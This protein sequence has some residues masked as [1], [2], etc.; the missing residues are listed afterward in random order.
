MIKGKQ[1]TILRIDESKFWA[2]VLKSGEG[3]CW[4]WIG[5]LRADGYGVIRSRSL[6]Y[7]AHR[8]AYMLAN[9]AVP[10]GRVVDHT[11]G[12]KACCN[13]EHLQAVT[14]S[15]NSRRYRVVTYRG[16]CSRGHSVEFGQKC[17]R[18]NTERVREWS[19]RNPQRAAEIQ[20][21]Y[22]WK[23]KERLEEAARTQIEETVT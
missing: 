3:K 10:R 12:C 13:P 20:E 11:C 15:E 17:R 6:M 19:R 8:V 5:A 2:K 14:Q 16:M 22:Y 21:R 9:G 18:C 1:I 7:K 4:P 23:R